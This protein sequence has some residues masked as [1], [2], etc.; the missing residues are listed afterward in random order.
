[1][2]RRIKKL[3]VLIVL[4]ALGVSWPVGLHYRAKSHLARYNAG[5]KRAGEKLSIDELAPPP[6]P[7]AFNAAMDVVGIA[8]FLGTSGPGGTN[9]PLVMKYAGPGKAMVGWLQPVLPNSETTNVWPG[10]REEITS[11]RETI[12]A[13]CSSIQRAPGVALDL[14]YRQGWS[15]SLPQLSNVKSAAVVDSKCV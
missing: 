2:R 14:N 12:E 11:N 5:L 9:Y 7:E 8:S 1:M 4:L 13:L 6:E 3:A 15:M 10:L